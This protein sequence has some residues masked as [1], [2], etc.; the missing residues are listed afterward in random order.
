MFSV[1]SHPTSD[2]SPLNIDVH[3][4]RQHHRPRIDLTGALVGPHSWRLHQ[5]VIDLLR[6]EI[7]PV[8]EL[9]LAGV[10]DV[11]AAGLRALEACLEDARQVDCRIT[12]RNLG[13]VPAHSH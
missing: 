9:N 10:T 2:H 7:P 12:V 11:D 4:E 13:P 8:M 5:A 3:A 6:S 1:L